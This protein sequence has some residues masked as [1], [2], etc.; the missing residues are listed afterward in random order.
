M[1]SQHMLFMP[2]GLRSTKRSKRHIRLWQKFTHYEE[3]IIQVKG[4]VYREKNMIESN[5]KS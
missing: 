2:L 4:G 5:E 3:I 1:K